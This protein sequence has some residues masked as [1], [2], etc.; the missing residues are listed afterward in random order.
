MPCE[1]AAVLAVMCAGLEARG[2]PALV[3]L[4]VFG[5]GAAREL[6]LGTG[7]NRHFVWRCARGAGALALGKAGDGAGEAELVP[8]RV[9]GCSRWELAPGP[10]A[11]LKAGGPPAEREA[12]ALLLPALLE[13][14]KMAFRF[15]WQPQTFF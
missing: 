15:P 4:S 6:S 14:V 9:L 7:A 8:P 5:V 1:R 10:C 2:M 11:L 12:R 3:N 13:R